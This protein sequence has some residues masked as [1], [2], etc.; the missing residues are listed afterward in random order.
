M[1]AEKLIP[2]GLAEVAY[3]GGQWQPLAV[4]D[5]GI[6]LD[7]RLVVGGVGLTGRE[8]SL[9]MFGV[10]VQTSALRAL[11][12]LAEKLDLTIANVVASP[13]ALAS[14]TPHT[15]AIILDIG[16]SGTD[17]CLIKND[18]LAGTDWTPFGGYFFT[19]SLA[20]AMG[21][22]P[23]KARNSKH[24]FANG[25]LPDEESNKIEA[26][27]ESSL[28][29]WHSSVMDILV[30]LS[31]GKPLPRRIYLTGGGS[32]LPGLDRF[33][34]INATPFDAA[35]EVSK[36]GRQSLLA[37]KDLTDGMNYNLMP[38]TLGLAIG[39]PESG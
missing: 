1:R 6:L 29:R 27:L 31:I 36:L 9:S 32:L 28:E 5:A 37:I 20:K 21:I 4:S 30:R 10:A 8:I 33:L 19:Q 18:A 12:V 22:G 24:A 34:K 2:E 14:I 13:H 7:G 26:Y 23:I 16:F 17:V 15:E 35:P 11:E 3:E 25:L 38:L 39:L